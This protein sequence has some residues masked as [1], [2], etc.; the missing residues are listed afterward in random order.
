MPMSPTVRAKEPVIRQIFIGRG[1]DVIVPDALERKLYVIRK[2]ASA[3]DPG[4]QAHAQ[5]RVLRAQHELPHGHLQ[6]PAAGRPGRA[7]LPGPAGS[8]RGLGARAGAPALLDQ[9]VPRMAARAPVPHGRAQ[10]RDQHR[11]GQLQLDAR[12]RGRDEVAGA[13]RRPEEALPDQLRRPE[14]H[15]DLR[16]RAR[17]AGDGGLPAGPRG[18]DD[19]P[20]GLGAARAD[21]PAPPRVL[22]VPRRDARAVG[23]P[24]RDGVHRRQADRRHARPQRPAPGALPRHRRR[25]RRDGLRVRRAAD[26]RSQGRQEVAPAAGQDVP[27]RPRAGP[28]RRRRRAEAP[29]RVRQAVPAVDRDRA[30]P[31]RF[32]RRPRRRRRRRAN[33]CSIASRPSAT[34]RRT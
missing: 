8:A 11:Q 26:S 24:G 5:P 12:P 7:V 6:G 16:Q 25:H 9:H 10:R 19:D 30:R 29:A 1:P 27:D 18:D 31:S 20:R 14:R 13:R 23:R 17:V 22:R 21:G 15:R 32:D 34:R 28:H 4:A 3:R 33:R 2:T